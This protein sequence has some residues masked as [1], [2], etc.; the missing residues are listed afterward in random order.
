MTV[1]TCR[2]GFGFAG[3]GPHLQAVQALVQLASHLQQTY[4]VPKT[5]QIAPQS[6]AQPLNILWLVPRAC[7]CDQLIKGPS[8]AN[9]QAKSRSKI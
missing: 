6:L 5:A 4:Q 2:T 1:T 7:L 3:K 9:S 8:L